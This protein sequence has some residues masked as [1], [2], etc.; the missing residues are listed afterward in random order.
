MIYMLLA[1][2]F[3]EI[4]ALCPLDMLRRAG[5]TVKTVGVTGMT[6]TGSHGISVL[7]DIAPDEASETP[8]ML[9]LPGGMPGTTNLDEAAITDRLLNETL[10]SGGHVGAICAAPSILGKRGL[11]KGKKATCFPGFE[12]TLDGAILSDQCVVT[13]GA[14]TT[15]VGMGAAMHFGHA[16]LAVLQ[17]REAA[18]KLASAAKIKL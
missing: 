7:A 18:D 14:I 16:L 17:G 6:V 5:I 8:S 3:E 9:I 13:D 12:H 2:G 1:D 4:E 11:L 15:A 10:A